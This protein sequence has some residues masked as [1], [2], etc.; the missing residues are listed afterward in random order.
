MDITPP[1]STLL[2]HSRSKRQR[3]V[4]S[5]AEF[6]HLSE[7]VYVYLCQRRWSTGRDIKDTLALTN[8]QWRDILFYLRHHYGVVSVPGKGIFK[9]KATFTLWLRTAR[10]QKKA[11]TLIY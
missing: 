10:Q 7:R 2:S 6:Q 9:D 4:L 5:T 3:T 1:K 8:N 11:S